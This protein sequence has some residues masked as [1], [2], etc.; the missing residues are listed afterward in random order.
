MPT[1]EFKYQEPFPL[2]KDETEYYLL[3]K[4]HVSVTEFEGKSI[5]KIESEG[6]T[7]LANNTL[8][9]TSFMLRPEH[10]KK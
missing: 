9:D 8:R 5:I 4:D 2:V 7:K 10:I 6:L 1:P 3:T